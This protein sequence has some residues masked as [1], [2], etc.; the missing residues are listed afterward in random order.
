[1]QHFW[2]LDRISAALSPEPAR[3][4]HP[5]SARHI[6]SGFFPSGTQSFRAITTDTR[7]LEAGDCFVALRGDKYDAHDF[8]EQAVTA[9][10]GALVVS[11][12]PELGVFSIPVFVVEDTLVALGDLATYWRKAWG[13]V[14][15][16]VAGSNGKTS[17]KELITAA[18]APIYSVHATTAN[19]NNRVGVPL[20][21][22][23]I[24]SEADIAVVEVGTNAVGEVAMLRDIALPD[25]AVVTCIAEEH[26]EGLGDLQGVL[27]EE[28][29]IFQGASLAI[30]PSD[31]PEIGEVA[32][33]RGV[34]TIAAG[35]TKIEGDL[36]PDSWTIAADGRGTLTFG[37][38][39]IAPSLRGKHNLQNALL[40]LA[41]ARECGVSLEIAG[42]GIASAN[43]P[44]MRTSWEQIGK[45]TLINDAYNANPGSM[46]AALQLL[47]A[48]TT[49]QRV[50]IL[51]AMRELGP[52]ESFYHDEVA[53]AALQSNADLIAGLGE[54]GDALNRIEGDKSKVVTASDI[55]ELWNKLLP[56]LHPEATILLKASRGVR[57]ERLLPH[58]TSWASA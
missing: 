25:I 16:A 15:V 42:A 7:S 14:V 10:A 56:R 54:L 9:G 55:D 37:E 31:Q 28:A 23:A 11:R 53:R 58:I 51:G 19:Y 38:T 26:L 3:F 8:L 41:V 49:S 43:Q 24:P 48:S 29:S 52:N 1:M 27:D 4:A 45:A 40:A 18:L 32:R 50:A 2:T 57:L 17:T 46:R 13:K 33:Q 35:L 12:A 39:T 5:R 30:V 36:H 21:L 6:D 22:L 44:A 34:R 20:T 47:S